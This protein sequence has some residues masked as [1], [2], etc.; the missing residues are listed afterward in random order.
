MHKR[1]GFAGLYVTHDQEEAMVV[2]DRIVVMDHGKVAESGSHDEL[3]AR[4]GVY[5][6][7][8]ADALAAPADAS[9]RESDPAAPPR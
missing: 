5:A 7:L 3:L 6:R 2:S 4:G 1:L 8:Y 9:E